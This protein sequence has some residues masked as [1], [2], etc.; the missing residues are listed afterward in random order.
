MSRLCKRP[1]VVKANDRI[2]RVGRNLSH[3]ACKWKNAVGF[4]EREVLSAGYIGNP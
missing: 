2:M 3:P 4:P 1:C